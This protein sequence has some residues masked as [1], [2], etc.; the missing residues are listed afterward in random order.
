MVATTRPSGVASTAA[1]SPMPTSVREPAGSHADN[2]LIRPNSPTEASV[3]ESCLVIMASA[4]RDICVTGLNHY[5]S[6]IGH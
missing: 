5:G 3:C 6:V 2:A 1:S 4:V